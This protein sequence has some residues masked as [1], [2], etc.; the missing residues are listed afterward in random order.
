MVLVFGT[1]NIDLDQYF[2][3]VEIDAQCWHSRKQI[4][5]KIIISMFVYL[6]TAVWC[7]D[8]GGW[9]CGGCVDGVVV[10]WKYEDGSNIFL[11]AEG[12]FDLISSKCLLNSSKRCLVSGLLRKE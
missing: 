10:D 8:G 7:D 12:N 3:S 1:D 5:M 4:Q 2:D 11:V 9:Y 6:L